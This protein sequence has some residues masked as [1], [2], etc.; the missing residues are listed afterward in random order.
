M[1]WYH[2]SKTRYVPGDLIHGKGGW[3]F[4]NPIVFMTSSVIPHYTIFNRAFEDNW[5]V[6]QVKPLRKVK[7]GYYFDEAG[8]ELVEVI[9]KI[10]NARGLCNKDRH[11][12]YKGSM[13]HWKGKRK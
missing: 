6:Y 11:S 10:G 12:H 3:S 1:K 2:A 13:V 7:I 9:K 8:C 4:K 5:F